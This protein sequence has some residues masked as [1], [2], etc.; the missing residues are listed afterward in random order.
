M[1]LYRLKSWVQPEYGEIYDEKEEYFLAK[2][3]QSV[4]NQIDEEG[5]FL[6]Q[7]GRGSKYYSMDRSEECY[8]LEEL[9]ITE[10]TQNR[11]DED[12]EDEPY[13]YIP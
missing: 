3:K 12:E 13:P 9:N 5:I 10:V 8:L 4:I 6:D 2:D 11:Y 7:N 1:R